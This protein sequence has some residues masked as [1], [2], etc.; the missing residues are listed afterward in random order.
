MT[1]PP[2]V[3]VEGRLDTVRQPTE[4]ALAEEDYHVATIGNQHSSGVTQA[5]HRQVAGRLFL[6]RPF[7][8]MGQDNRFAENRQSIL[9]S[10]LFSKF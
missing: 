4:V 9:L 6:G 5:Y 10:S 2:F 8:S 1:S 3:L 7:S